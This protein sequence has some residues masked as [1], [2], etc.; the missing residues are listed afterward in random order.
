MYQLKP[1]TQRSLGRALWQPWLSLPAIIAVLVLG[2]V[3]AAASA[4]SLS[5]STFGVRATGT[6]HF[7]NREATCSTGLC[8]VLVKKFNAT[9]PRLKVV[10]T[11]TC[12]NCDTST[13]ATAIRAGNPPDVVGLND[14]DVSAFST[15]DVL[16]NLTKYINALSYKKYLSPGH[17]ALGVYK[18]QDYAVPYLGDLSVLWYNKKLFKEAGL[19]PNDPPTTFASILSDAKKITALGHGIYGFTFAGDCQGCLGFVM[20][21]EIW[22][23]TSRLIEGPI[24]K[25]RINI[26]NNSPLKQLLELYRTIWKDKLAPANDRTDSGGTWGADFE[27]GKIGIMPEGYGAYPNI[28]KGI[29]TAA[30][31]IAPLPGPKGGYS[32]FDGGDDFVIPAGAKNPSGAWEFIKWVLE[33]KQQE[34][35]PKYGY[36]PILTNILTPAYNKAYPYDAVALKALAKGYAPDTTIYD[37]AIN[38]PNSP[39]FRMFSEAVYTSNMKGALQTG[40]TGF[41]E[42]ARSADDLSS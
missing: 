10:L 33:N 23:T 12:G 3:P 36:T 32:T 37:Q 39:W 13:L 9:H 30:A 5:A 14:I 11:E 26:A 42:A 28:I 40:Q 6:V 7:W 34:L 21:P 38:E 29:G 17:L 24:G 19:N 22:A 2:L 41:E 25:Q 20:L 8:K 4:K 15:K 31:G 35:F 16:M 18:G 1:K 27:A